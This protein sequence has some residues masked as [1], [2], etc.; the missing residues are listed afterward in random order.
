MFISM[1]EALIWGNNNENFIA[2]YSEG[3]RLCCIF[4]WPLSYYFVI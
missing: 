3:I 4:I 2:A 1:K